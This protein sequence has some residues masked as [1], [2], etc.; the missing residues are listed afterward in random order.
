MIENTEGK[1]VTI[2][3]GSK[4]SA[5]SDEYKDARDLGGRLAEAGFTICTGGYLGIMEA[6]SRGAREKGGRVFGIVMN[7]F[8][9]EPNRYLTDK[10]AT[11]HF[12]DRLQN[13]ITRSVGFVA[14]RGGMG[15]VTEISLVWNKLQTG[16]LPR[17]P[18]VLV[19]DCWKSVVDSW[20]E[21]LVVSNA[22]VGFLDFASNAEEACQVITKKA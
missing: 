17:R 7:Q 11:D 9:S 4:C 13:L 22:D 1:I 21:N 19:G 8:K 3:G 6:A 20:T 12:Y 15:T 2:F 18:L 10:V 14:F 5:D 16:V